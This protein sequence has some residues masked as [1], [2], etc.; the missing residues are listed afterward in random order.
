[1]HGMGRVNKCIN[2]IF[3][4]YIIKLLL[5]RSI[6][7]NY[8]HNKYDRDAHDKDDIDDARDNVTIRKN[9]RAS[10]IITA[11]NSH[12]SEVQNSFHKRNETNKLLKERVSIKTFFNEKRT[13]YLNNCIICWHITN[14]LE[15]L[16]IDLFLILKKRQ[17][18]SQTE[19]QLPIEQKYDHISFKIDDQINHVFIPQEHRCLIM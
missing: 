11:K 6:N 9:F 8:G 16:S 10:A 3:T 5:F 19:F 7:N 13:C 12:F 1:M 15:S 18:K 4:D 17:T 14:T 2:S